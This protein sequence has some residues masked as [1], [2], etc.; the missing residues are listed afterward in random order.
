M[1][2]DA[3]TREPVPAALLRIEVPALHSTEVTAQC[4]SDTDGRFELSAVRH[5]P[6]AARLVVRGEHH[7]ELRQAVP[8]LGELQIS[9]VARRRNLLLG[10]TRWAREMGWAGSSEPTP[11]HVADM[12]SKQNRDGA[13][14][15][16]AGIEQA[17]YGPVPPGEETEHSLTSAT[18]PLDRPVPHRR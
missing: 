10:L 12:A 5:L 13:R 2:V 3:N 15:W 8:P 7:S 4:Q 1:V 6:A 9:L 11:A 16:A 17:A 14:A 18:P